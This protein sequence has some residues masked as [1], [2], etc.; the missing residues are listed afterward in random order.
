MPHG[1]L[2]EAHA[3]Q[4]GV[5]IFPSH[6]LCMKQELITLWYNLGLYTGESSLRQSDMTESFLLWVNVSSV[7]T[8][9][10]VDDKW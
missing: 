1:A 3:E 6:G 8:Q 2:N 9:G 10:E 4:A 5:L 7:Y